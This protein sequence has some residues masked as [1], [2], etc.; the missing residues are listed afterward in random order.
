MKRDS[1]GRKLEASLNAS[2]NCR[3]GHGAWSAAEWPLGR[4]LSAEFVK[5]MA[6][7]GYEIASPADVHAAPPQVLQ[8]CFQSLHGG[9]T[10]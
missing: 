9:G 3:R 8:T 6:D 2:V 10:P 7:R 4:R 5:C 1:A